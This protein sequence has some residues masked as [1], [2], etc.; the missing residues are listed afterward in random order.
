M[1][2]ELRDIGVVK[3]FLIEPTAKA[4]EEQGN[5]YRS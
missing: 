3:L 5:V 2:Y 4:I 1:P